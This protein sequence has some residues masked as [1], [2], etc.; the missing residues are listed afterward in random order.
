VLAMLLS[1][2]SNVTMAKSAVS[3]A[4]SSSSLT[5]TLKV[6]A[7]KSH[8]LDHLR[9]RQRFDVQLYIFGCDTTLQCGSRLSTKF[10]H[11]HCKPTLKMTSQIILF[12]QPRSGS[13]YVDLGCTRRSLSLTIKMQAIY[14]SACSQVSRTSSFLHIR[15]QRAVASK[16]HGY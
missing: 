1:M 8:A 14:S 7:S 9:R 13:K 12:S 6:V 4:Q 3:M 2:Y 5:C 15:S 11:N 16:S 10:H